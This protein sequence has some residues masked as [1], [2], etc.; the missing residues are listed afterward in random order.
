L[1]QRLD[2]GPS[3]EAEDQFFID[4][5]NK[6]VP[7]LHDRLH[8]PYVNRWEAFFDYPLAIFNI[9]AFDLKS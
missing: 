2:V 7:A 6:T 8:A 4:L 5:E 1:A 9:H 3:G